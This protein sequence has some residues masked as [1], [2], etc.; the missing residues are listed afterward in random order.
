[1]SCVQSGAAAVAD[2]AKASGVG[3]CTVATPPFTTMGTIIDCEG[4]L[5]AGALE[6]WR[7]GMD[8]LMCVGNFEG[9]GYIQSIDTG[10]LATPVA[11]NAGGGSTYLATDMDKLVIPSGGIVNFK[12]ATSTGDYVT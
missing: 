7:T 3:D 12:G 5:Q 8:E 2:W 11:T 1:M 9:A 4:F 6:R 10:A